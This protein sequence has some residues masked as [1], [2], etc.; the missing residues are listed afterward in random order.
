MGYGV[1]G[2]ILGPIIVVVGSLVWYACDAAALRKL[3]SES[4]DESVSVRRSHGL[5]HG[6][7]SS[8][9]GT[10][11]SHRIAPSPAR[12]TAFERV[13]DENVDSSPARALLTKDASP[14]PASSM[15]SPLLASGTPALKPAT[16]SRKSVQKTRA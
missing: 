8:L 12:E 7:G 10:P 4:L 1:F 6:R 16:A 9:A 15:N 13:S 3:A 2:V 5:K 14:S 11:A